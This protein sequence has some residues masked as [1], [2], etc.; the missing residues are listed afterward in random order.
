MLNNISNI[1]RLILFLC[2]FHF[3]IIYLLKSPEKYYQQ[4]KGNFCVIYI[5]SVTNSIFTYLRHISNLNKILTRSNYKLL[6]L[7]TDRELSVMS[8]Y[9]NILNLNVFSSS[10]FTQYMNIEPYAITFFKD[11]QKIFQ[12]QM[13]CLSFLQNDMYFIN[14]IY[15]KAKLR[16]I[17][18]KEHPRNNEHIM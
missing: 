1:S 10:E 15:N 9:C 11:K 2:I 4:T 7:T 18:T 16:L 12:D 3:S 17:G 13:K 8:Y 6:I 14:L 5:P